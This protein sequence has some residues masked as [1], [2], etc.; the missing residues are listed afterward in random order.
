MVS[1]GL[2]RGRGKGPCDLLLEA[3]ILEDQVIHKISSTQPIKDSKYNIPKICLKPYMSKL[4]SL[5]KIS[6]L[7]HIK[8]TSF[9]HHIFLF[10]SNL[11]IGGSCI[12]KTSFLDSSFAGPLVEVHLTSPETLL[13]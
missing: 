10:L 13:P 9:F 6:H 3:T 5:S 8:S 2:P 4:R 7:R 11:T 1:S 12:T